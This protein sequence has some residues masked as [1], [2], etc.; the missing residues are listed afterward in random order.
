M[1]VAVD[2][3]CVASVCG[4]PMFDMQ[5]LACVRSVVGWCDQVV[6]V[7]GTTTW[8]VLVCARLGAHTMRA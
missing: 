5:K 2:G 4:G 6:V 8:C 3:W 1:V 7:C